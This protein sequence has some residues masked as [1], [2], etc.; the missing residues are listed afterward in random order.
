MNL[1]HILVVALG[2]V[3]VGGLV[4]TLVWLLL[5]S[6]PDERLYPSEPDDDDRGG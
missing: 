2:F 1:L 5:D 6:D 4:G 3:V